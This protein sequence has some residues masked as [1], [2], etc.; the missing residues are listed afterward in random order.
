MNTIHYD[1]S[2]ASTQK[3]IREQREELEE[4]FNILNLPSAIDQRYYKIL[5]YDMKRRYESTYL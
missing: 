4:N 5:L 1:I 3:D 2:R